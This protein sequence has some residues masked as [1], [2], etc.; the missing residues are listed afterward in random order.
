MPSGTNPTPSGRLGRFAALVLL[1]MLLGACAT[2]GPADIAALK[3]PDPLYA[4]IYASVSDGGNV[5]PAVDVSA[6]DPQ[7]LRQVVDYASPYP[8]G[9]IVV[10]PYRRFLYLVMENGKA[11]RYGVGVAKAGLEFVGEANLARKANWP[12]WTPTPD[13]IKREPARYQPYAGGMDGG[14][15][16]PLGARALYLF[17]DGRDTLYRI[18]GTNEPWSIG[19]AVSSGCVR[20]LNQDIIDLNSRVQPG[21][22]VIVLGPDGT[23]SGMTGTQIAGLG[24]PA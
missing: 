11:M 17:K 13:M 20:L 14:L 1:P 19:K 23:D 15:T 10:D 7:F 22:R 6:I 2:T 4:S 18:H 8:A 24:E 3:A 16:N 21:T 9:T 5:V 12:H